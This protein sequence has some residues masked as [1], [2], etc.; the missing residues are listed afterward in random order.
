[1]SSCKRCSKRGSKLSMRCEWVNNSTERWPRPL[2]LVSSTQMLR[3]FTLSPSFLLPSPHSPKLFLLS[4]SFTILI[5]FSGQGILYQRSLER[6][7]WTQQKRRNGIW[8]ARSG[9]PRRSYICLARATRGCIGKSNETRVPIWKQTHRAVEHTM[10]VR[11]R[12][13][14]YPCLSSQHNTSSSHPYTFNHRLTETR[15]RR[16]RSSARLCVDPYR[17]HR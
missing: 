5:Y 16:K 1:M 11:P 14:W 4:T 12:L 6:D 13:A 9:I 7:L 2:L 10:G 17:C 15:Y 8:M 3:Y